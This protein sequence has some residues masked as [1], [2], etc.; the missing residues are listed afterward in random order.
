MPRSPDHSG[1][2]Q[3]RRP[4]WLLISQWLLAAALALAVPGGLI[5]LI[6]LAWRKS[7]LQTDPAAYPSRP[8]CTRTET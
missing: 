3:D 1:T 8:D 4:D 6:C 7:V 5:V 2:R